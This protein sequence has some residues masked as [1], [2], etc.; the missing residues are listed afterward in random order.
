MCYLLRLMVICCVRLA[1]LPVIL[2]LSYVFIFINPYHAEFLKWNNP[3]SIFGTL[4][5][6]FRD[7][8]M[9]TQSWSANSIE[10]GQTATGGKG[11]SLSVLAG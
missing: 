7:I 2:S 8:K 9:K 3:T 4:H 6:H 5:Y 1:I 10:P 11:Y